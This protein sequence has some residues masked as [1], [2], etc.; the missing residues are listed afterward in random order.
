MT[1]L[2]I[3]GV[4]LALLLALGLGSSWFSRGT[5]KDY[6]LASHTIGP[7]MLMLSL[8]GTN[9]TA[10]AL[11]GSTGEAYREG[12]GV[13][14]MLASS[15]GIVH[16]LCFFLIGVKLWTLG[17]RYGY[18]TQIQFFR[19]RLETNHI[20]LLLFP[21]LVALVV[22]YLLI[23]V[24]GA[25]LT[26]NGVTRGA[27]PDV[28]AATAGGVPPWIASA[29]ICCVVLVYVFF[30]GMRG[31]T[32]ANS[33]QTA[34]FL[35]MGMA[36]FLVIVTQLGGKESLLENLRAASGAVA[37]DK[38]TREH[39]PK[40]SFATYLLIPLSVGMFPHIFQHWLTARSAASFKLPVVAYPL[41]IML[42]WAPCVLIGLWATTEA[43]AVPA[44]VPANAVLGYLV[45]KLAGDVL[46]G[47]LTAGILAAIMSSLDSQFL[48]LGTMFTEDIAVHYAGKGRFT[49]GQVV[50][51]ARGF[52]VAVVAVT[53][54]LSLFPSPPRVFQLGLWCFSG[55]TALFPLVF[56][57]LYWKGLTRLGAYASVLTAIVVWSWLFY[58]S[59]FGQQAGYTVDI[60]I[61]QTTLHT[62]PVATIFLASATALVVVSWLTPRPSNA[63]L[64]RF[65]PAPGG[66]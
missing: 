38:L 63:T 7:V 11:V 30:G 50:W 42:L 48:C 29:V 25:G 62:M 61:G 37:A 23:G 10:F 32:W 12:A 65:F 39:I 19:D 36:S 8:F 3:I 57:A 21:F 59:D 58:R 33:A 28:F 17:K 6:L 52:V 31:T 4:Y 24:I 47:F 2:V 18:T 49:D 64:A 66:K 40:L 26:I 55:F 20:G 22:A 45:S 9:M 15:S 1:Q 60:P 51:L 14:G 44:A 43:A 46:G 56:A 27:F 34:F 53:Y 5:S 13:Y 35:I 54:T 16:S 41:L